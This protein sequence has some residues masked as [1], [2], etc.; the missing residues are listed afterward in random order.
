MFHQVASESDPSDK[1]ELDGT[2]SGGA[3]GR[4]GTRRQRP[5][6]ALLPGAD[7]RPMPPDRP[8]AGRGADGAALAGRT[9]AVADP[10]G[11]AA[12]HA[13]RFAVVLVGRRW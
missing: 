12:V 5:P 8:S 6:G 4:A 9:P 3:E 11:A 7:V 1:A 2:V 10:T 13:G